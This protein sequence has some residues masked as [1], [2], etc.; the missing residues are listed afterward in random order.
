MVTTAA[1]GTWVS[2]ISAQLAARHE[3]GPGW[4]SAVG[5]EVWWTEPRPTEGGRT[6]LVRRLED[7][8]AATVLPEPWNVRSRV[9]EYGGRS[10][11]PLPDG[12]VVF[13]EFSDQ[14]LYRHSPDEGGEP[15]PLTPEPGRPAGLRYVEP[16]LAP[17]GDEVWCVREAFTGPAPTDLTRAIVAIPIDGTAAERP[18]AVRV[19]VRDTHFLAGPAI[20][21]D[22]RRLAWI[23]WQHPEMPWDSTVLRVAGIGRSGQIGAPRTVAGGAGVSVVQAEWSGPS[24]LLAVDDSGG[25][26]NL[27]LIDVEGGAAQVDLCRRDEEFGGALWQLGMRWFAPLP[28]G[29]VAVVHGR[30]STRLGVL[31]P[32]T[33]ALVDVRTPHT[34][35]AATL[36]VSD[37]GAVVGVAGA[38]DR[39]FDVVRV[40]PSSSSWAGLAARA[41]DD[42]V[43]PAYLPAPEA[44]T[45]HGVGGRDVH[46]TLYPP[47]SPDHAAP[48]GELPPYVVFV[49]GGPT[50]R[51]PVVRDLEIAFFTSR[52]LGVV[53][54]EYGGSTGHGREYRDRLREQWGVV[55]VQDSAT[56]ARALVAEGLAD[57][58]RLAIRGGSAGG[59]TT[60]A[61][62]T[63]VDD[64]AC[65][66]ILYPILD[67]AG[68]RSGETHD[69]E[70]Q[71]LESLVGPWPDTRQRYVD[72]SPVNRA[73]RLSV[74]FVLLQGLDDVICPPVQAERFLRKVAGRGIPHAYLTF[75]GEQHGFRHEETITAALEAELS[76]YGQV[77]GFEP[78]D[79]PR[80]DLGDTRQGH[81]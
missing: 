41:A 16:V 26:W 71:Y 8:A 23:G 59:W 67:L 49:H 48:P 62:L 53:E 15:V 50:S 60:A 51:S 77:F 20:A 47:R 65:G 33:G 27:H 74:P 25:W 78:V 58:A 38:P 3:G 55:D 54:V 43:P 37:D 68:W 4:V 45:F 79:V 11:L 35:W 63:S 7:G 1:Y 36:A 69:F 13:A 30:S 31:D 42:G 29:R 64:F 81:G 21:P 39:A 17:R 10:Y 40:D 76:L 56:V 14:R 46:A 44:R 61:A 18:D 9:H 70:S 34:E 57:P 22:G 28:D 80:L 24:R 12:A 2:P 32:R 73:D 52:G 6:A 5:R 19:L 72:R 75:E 66:A